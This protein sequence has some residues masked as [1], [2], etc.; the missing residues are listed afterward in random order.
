VE[1]DMGSQV[2]P[3]FVCSC[4]VVAWIGR[5]L[6]GPSPIP[7]AL[8]HAMVPYFSN[9][10]G[11]T[12]PGGG[13]QPFSQPSAL[14]ADHAALDSLPG[15]AGGTQ[16]HAGDCGCRH[17][18]S[19]HYLQMGRLA[20][21]SAAGSSLPGQY[22]NGPQLVPAG[23]S[24][25]LDCPAQASAAGGTHLVGLFLYQTGKGEVRELAIHRGLT[26]FHGKS[27][28]HPPLINSPRPTASP[29]APFPFLPSV[30]TATGRRP[31]AGG[32]G[33]RKGGWCRC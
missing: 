19:P 22:T 28:I 32:K 21:G 33:S 6:A 3:C 15:G 16:R 20:A 8:P 18:G 13:D 17:V 27:P 4:W 30:A 12:F 11:A 5:Y 7:L 26:C 25:P 1:E 9:S 23:A 2:V 29:P 24:T 31:R 14:P 10:V